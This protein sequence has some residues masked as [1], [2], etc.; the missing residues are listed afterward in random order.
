MTAAFQTMG[1]QHICMQVS[2]IFTFRLGENP[3]WNIKG[4]EAFHF[5]QCNGFRHPKREGNISS[6]PWFWWFIAEHLYLK[7]LNINGQRVPI[8]L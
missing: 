5:S 2:M 6:Q 4:T 3:M 7:S 1:E 8:T